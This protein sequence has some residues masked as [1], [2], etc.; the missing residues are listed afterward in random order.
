VKKLGTPVENLFV[1][2]QVKCD[3]RGSCRRFICRQQATF[4][5][6]KGDI[7]VLAAVLKC[8]A[9][10]F[11]AR[12]IYYRA[13][14]G[15]DQLEVGIAVPVQRMIESEKAGLMFTIDP[16]TIDLSHISIDSC[17]RLGRSCVC[18]SRRL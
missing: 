11:E 18:C 12:A 15:F 6:I 16:T 7:Q 9:S 2:V 10:L 5:E 4:L 14:N 13:D 3:R 17:I 1:A 8:W